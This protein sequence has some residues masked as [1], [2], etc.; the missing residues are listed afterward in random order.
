[1]QVGDTVEYI[2]ETP[3][4]FGDNSIVKGSFGTVVLAGFDTHRVRFWCWPDRIPNISRFNLRL[5]KGTD[6]VQER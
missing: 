2:C 5:V 4:A 6:N 3:Y 1:M